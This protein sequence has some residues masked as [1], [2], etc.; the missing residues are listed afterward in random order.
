MDN[1]PEILKAEELRTLDVSGLMAQ[2]ALAQQSHCSLETIK[3][4]REEAI[5][6]VKDAI[7]DKT[8]HGI[9]IIG[10]N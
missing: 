1:L 8:R 9:P 3:K 6:R 4:W 5:A 7:H 10:S 2:L